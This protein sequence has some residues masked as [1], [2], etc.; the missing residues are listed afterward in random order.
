MA[1]FDAEMKA[2][3]ESPLDSDFGLSLDDVVSHSDDFGRF[4]AW[5]GGDHA[6][7]KAVLQA[8]QDAGMSPALFSAYESQE[9]VGDYRGSQLGWLNYTFP[10]GDPVSDA[11]FVAHHMVDVS[12]DMGQAPSWI[13]AGNP[14]DFVPQDVKDMGNAHF[15][16]LPAH[17]V[18]R[19]YI[20]STAAACWG[21]YYPQGL[22]QAYNQVQDYAYPL[23]GALKVIKFWGGKITGGGGS[24]TPA[25]PDKPKPA[26]PAKP[27]KPKP[28]PNEAP[29]TPIFQQ[30]TKMAFQI[31]GNNHMFRSGNFLFNKNTK[32]TAK[33]TQPT[34]NGNDNH[35]QDVKQGNESKPAPSAP[36]ASLDLAWLDSIDGTFVGGSDQCYGLASAWAMHNGTPQLI[37]TNA[38]RQP[39]V[40]VAEPQID[41]GMAAANIAS[42]YPWEAWGWEIIAHPT[43]D[44]VKAGDICCMVC[45]DPR[46]W[47]PS[48]DGV[49][50]GHVCI[51]GQ[52]SGGVFSLWEQN[53]TFRGGTTKQPQRS[54]KPT[55]DTY[56]PYMIHAIRKK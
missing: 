50:Y 45:D 41:V 14:V 19:A 27:P 31:G 55:L 7:I 40:E 17:T 28:K 51:A 37:S 43:R 3:L 15:A 39:N 10:H 2:F 52:D 32:A 16:S 21:A 53:G 11:S 29:Q 36:S 12:N 5:L 56:M 24:T 25:K 42:E 49:R 26:T 35:K 6:Q 46:G 8:V 9:G 4:S 22:T 34:K 44:Q 38:S 13:D 47:I 48:V 18:G 33:P 54:G 1:E 30:G 23:G 20:A